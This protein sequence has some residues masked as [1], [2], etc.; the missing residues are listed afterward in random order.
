MSVEITEANTLFLFLAK[1]RCTFRDQVQVKEKK[2]IGIP[3][4]AFI[5]FL[6]FSKIQQ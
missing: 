4:P 3:D 5:Q 2:D 1:C 6:M